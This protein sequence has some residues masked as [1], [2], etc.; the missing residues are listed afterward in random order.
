MEKINKISISASQRTLHHHI[1]I[2]SP[3]LVRNVIATHCE[4]HT[5]Q[6]MHTVGKVQLSSN[7]KCGVIPELQ[8]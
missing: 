4:H 1:N 7:V 5:K 2:H 6:I 3:M 8:N